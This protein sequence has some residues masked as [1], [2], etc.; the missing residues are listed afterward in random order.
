MIMK[1]NKY[2]KER[3]KDG[4]TVEVRN[5][6]VDKALRILKKK[7]I[8]DGFFQEMRERTF[9]ES[10]GT[11]RRKAKEAAT[12]RYKRKMQKRKEELGY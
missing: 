4:M 2:N 6:N 12:R 7:L 10:K 11:K 5:D 8:A 1:Y 3:E 9:Y